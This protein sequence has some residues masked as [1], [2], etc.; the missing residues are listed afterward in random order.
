MRVGVLGGG[1]LG[2]MIALAGYPL[3][4]AVRL[5]ET[6]SDACGGQVTELHV[7]DYRDHEAL[8]RFADGL[9]VV[10]YEFENVPVES[11]EYLARKLPVYPPPVSLEIAQDRLTEKTFFGA[12]GIPTAG[13]LAVDSIDDLARSVERYGLPLV[14]KT[15]RMGYDGKGQVIV[16]DES[17]VEFAWDRLRGVPLIA[18]SFV[19]FERE[20]SIIAV[21][22]PEGATRFYPLVENQ[23]HAGILRISRA[24]AAEISSALQQL[25]ED[26]AGRALDSLQY[27]GVLAIEFFSLGDELLANEMAPRVHNSGH[28]TIEGA[29]TSQFENHLRAV[30]GMPLGSIRPRGH[31]IMINIIG[32]LPLTSHVLATESAHLHLYGKSPR[33]GR[34]LG[35]VT[36]RADDSLELERAPYGLRIPPPVSID[37]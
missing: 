34:K 16:R 33:S 37:A 32:D 9:D 10:T 1:Q 11:A 12:R 36:L 20:L 28:W 26:Y 14:L 25:A 2:R 19:G 27:V 18:E 13:F 30:A 29:E 22:S 3:G 15:R 21:R 7:G 23:H 24:P 5:F 17:A 4:I 31:S 6:S 35:H 8:D